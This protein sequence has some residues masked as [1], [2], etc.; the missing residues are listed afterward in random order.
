MTVTSNAFERT[1]AASELRKGY[2]FKSA[3]IKSLL[4]HWAMN[5]WLSAKQLACLCR[6]CP[7]NGNKIKKLIAEGKQV[8]LTLFR[9]A[10]KENARAR[11]CESDNYAAEMYD[12]IH[13]R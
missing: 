3:F 9:K 7:T 1:Q 13:Y 5:G 11:E 4:N 2:S 10:D 12:D 6:S 8:D